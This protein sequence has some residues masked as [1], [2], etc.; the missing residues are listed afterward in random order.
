MHIRALCVDDAICIN[1]QTI[2][3][4]RE[5]YAFYLWKEK[6]LHRRCQSKLEKWK[7]NNHEH[8]CTGGDGGG[9]GWVGSSCGV[10]A[11]A[12]GQ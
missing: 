8:D 1:S 7:A 9:G 11:M 4:A 2:A 12:A 5:S 3:H 10:A 6:K